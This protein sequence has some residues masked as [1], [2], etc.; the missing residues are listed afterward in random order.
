LLAELSDCGWVCEG[1]RGGWVLARDAGEIMLADVFQRFVFAPLDASV[2]PSLAGIRD[3]LTRMESRSSGE[4]AVALGEL[5]FPDS[6]PR[7][8]EDRIAAA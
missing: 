4:L 3:I 2:P 6:P 7:G 1:V 5:F 8:G